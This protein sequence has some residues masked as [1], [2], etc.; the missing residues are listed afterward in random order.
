MDFT[1]QKTEN[2]VSLQELVIRVEDMKQNQDDHESKL[3]N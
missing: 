1:S 2:V 3:L